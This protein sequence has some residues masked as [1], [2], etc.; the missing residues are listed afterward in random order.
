[1]I[2]L[3]VGQVLVTSDLIGYGDLLCL[4]SGWRDGGEGDRGSG[5]GRRRHVHG[6]D[7]TWKEDD[8]EMLQGDGRGWGQP[9]PIDEVPEVGGGREEGGMEEYPTLA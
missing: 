4:L 2:G 1:M 6:R 7:S 5:R 8:M 9:C 3:G